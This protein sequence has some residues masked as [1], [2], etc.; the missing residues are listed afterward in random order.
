MQPKIIIADDHSMIRK[1]IKL[2][3]Q[4]NLGYKEVS[5]VTTCNE[6]MNELQKKQCSHLLLDIIFSDGTALEVIGNIKQL[7][8][9]L[10]IMIFSMQLA[11][12]Y[13]EAFRQYD[14]HHFLS[15]TL[16][17]EETTLCLRRFLNNEAPPVAPKNIFSQSNPFSLL[18]PR[19]LEVIHYLL[20][21]YQTKDISRTLNLSMSTIST[22]KKRIFEKTETEN[23]KQLL[24][25]ATL[26]NISF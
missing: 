12:V 16:G 1:G 15:K 24:E 17:E 9:E 26:Y 7:Y 19:E 13:G 5:E 21:G 10:K 23:F 2:I 25:L 8:P 4:S 18:S 3:L 6:L 11:E 22:L 20:N 14:V